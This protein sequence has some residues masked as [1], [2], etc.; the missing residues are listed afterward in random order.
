MS[1]S[2]CVPKIRPVSQANS[3]LAHFLSIPL[4]SII[5]ATAIINVVIPIAV[6]ATNQYVFR[7]RTMI[8]RHIMGSADRIENFTRTS[9]LN[10]YDCVLRPVRYAVDVAMYIDVVNIMNRL[11]PTRCISSYIPEIIMIEK[12]QCQAV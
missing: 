9:M 6:K 12:E 10:R 7:F 2:P 1:F 5:V 8:S 3:A 4:K 11:I